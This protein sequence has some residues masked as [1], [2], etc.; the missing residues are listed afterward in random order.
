MADKILLVEDD[1]WFA[2][3]IAESLK[4]AGY[5][6]KISPHAVAAIN[7]IDDF[8][9]NI[10]IMDL[11]L[12]G[13]TAFSLMNELQSHED[14]SAIP[15]IICSNLSAQLNLDDLKPYGA[16]ALLDKTT[17]TPKD[18]IYEIKNLKNE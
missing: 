12:T 16:K 13:S 11:L 6:I 8:N 9:P 7:D 18:I 3:T 1:Q 14:L 5:E 2:E 15:V 10:I 4:V 17:M